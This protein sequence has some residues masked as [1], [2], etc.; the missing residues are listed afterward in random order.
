[1]LKIKFSFR[2][3]NQSPSA[4]CVCQHV[5]GMLPGIRYIGSLL[6]DRPTDVDIRVM[7]LFTPSTGSTTYRTTADQVHRY[8]LFVCTYVNCMTYRREYT[9]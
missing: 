3:V 4:V 9:M 2:P 6:T 8:V 1:M 7:N 5:S